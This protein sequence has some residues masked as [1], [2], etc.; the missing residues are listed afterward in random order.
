[1]QKNIAYALKEDIGSGDIT[2]ALIPAYQKATA[3]LISREQAFISG[4]P[5]FNAIFKL[6]DPKI[7]ITWLIKEGDMIEKNQTLCVL[8][9]FTRSI[10]S[11]ERCALNFL[12]FMS[13]ITTRC[14]YFSQ[15]ISHTQVKLLDTR[16]TL[17]GLRSEQKYAVRQGGCYNHRFGLYDAF[18][19][20]E[21]HIQACGGLRQAIE[22]ANNKRKNQEIVVE[23]ESLQELK[24]ALNYRTTRILLDNFR[25]IDLCQAVLMTSKQ[26][27]LEVSGNIDIHNLVEVAETGVDFIS[28]GSLTKNC[29]AI[30][31]SLQIIKK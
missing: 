23:V 18:L 3:H 4:I 9:G 13:G 8:T 5:W 24:E 1:M 15:R 19:I 27:L 20:K 14:R 12:Q 17:P 2:A 22:K 31:F 16:K 30:D 7:N 11:A 28:L 21:N 25:I 29:Q 6:L 10:L 26:A